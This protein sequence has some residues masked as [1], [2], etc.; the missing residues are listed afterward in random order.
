MFCKNCGKEINDNAVICPKCG[1]PTNN[2]KGLKKHGGAH[3]NE[4]MS[5][6]IKIF[7]I[8]SCVASI[9]SFLIPLAWC[10]PMTIRYFRA[11]E[12]GEELGAG[13]K[14]CVLL[15]VNTIAGILMLCDK[16]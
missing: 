13:Y 2:F 1:V 6:A 14:V 9:F 3:A 5:L 8:I 12:N 4:G 10:L 7:L 16:Q 11:V 15:F